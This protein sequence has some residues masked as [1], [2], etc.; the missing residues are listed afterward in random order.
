[1]KKQCLLLL[2]MVL[3]GCLSVSAQFEGEGFY[4]IQNYDTKRYITIVDTVAGIDPVDIHAIQLITEGVESD[5]GTVIYIDSL[6][7]DSVVYTDD[8]VE[9]NVKG[10]DLQAQGIG[11]YSLLPL[12]LKIKENE[13][14][15]LGTQLYNAWARAYLSADFYYDVYIQDNG[16]ATNGFL[17]DDF[18][19]A[20]SGNYDNTRW[21]ITP[22]DYAAGFPFGV[23]ATVEGENGHYY[24]TLYTSFAYQIPEDVEGVVAAYGV[25]KAADGVATLSVIAEKGG[26]VPAFSPVVLECVSKKSS[27]NVLQPVVSDTEADSNNNL[28]TGNLFNCNVTTSL[29]GDKTTHRNQVANDQATMRVLGVNS[30]GKV[31]LFKSSDEFIAANSA[32]LVMENAEDEYLFSTETTGIGALKADDQHAKTYDLQGRNVGGNGRGIVIRNGKKMIVK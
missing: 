24:T 27:V 20:Q 28:L 7:L 25:K 16:G 3:F 9:Y 21:Y 14:D 8:V 30:E 26:I 18:D 23:N 5:P 11:T 4:R 1:M 22:I 29:K 31:G 10:V 15:N 2:V 12:P 19:A 32:Y 13:K 17:S 6:H